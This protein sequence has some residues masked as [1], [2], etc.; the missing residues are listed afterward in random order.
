MNYMMALLC[1][2]GAVGIFGYEYTTGST[3]F[4]ILGGEVSAG[5]ILLAMAVYNL[6]RWWSV[7]SGRKQQ[8]DMRERAYRVRERYRRERDQER[9]IDPT[10]DFTRPSEP[11]DSPPDRRDAGPAEEKRE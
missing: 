10:F 3:R 1:V 2:A 8:D 6:V 9:E 5:W 7:Q 4:H 11:F